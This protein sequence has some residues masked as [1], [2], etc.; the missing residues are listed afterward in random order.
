[1]E[2]EKNQPRKPKRQK[3]SGIGFTAGLEEAIQERYRSRLSDHGSDSRVDDLATYS[4]HL[5]R[6]QRI[7]LAVQR[8]ARTRHVSKLKLNVLLSA[9]RENKTYCYIDW[10]TVLLGLHTVSGRPPSKKQKIRRG[11]RKGIQDF[12]HWHTCEYDGYILFSCQFN[13]HHQ[14]ALLTGDS[15]LLSTGFVMHKNTRAWYASKN[16]ARRALIVNILTHVAS[17]R[18]P[19][20][21]PDWATCKLRED[22][23]GERDNDFCVLYDHKGNER[24]DIIFGV[25][26]FRG[27]DRIFSVPN[28]IAEYDGG[29]TDFCFRDLRSKYNSIT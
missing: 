12:F 18:Q 13:Y 24:N 15:I 9:T 21:D 23:R 14:T 1:V 17:R 19:L 20:V 10:S 7:K 16:D 22:M 8:S 11:H 28:V 29:W 26:F 25:L 2:G 4:I 3:H 27:D 6:C 5:T